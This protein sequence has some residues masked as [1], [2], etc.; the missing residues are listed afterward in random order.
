MFDSFFINAKK[1][2]GFGGKLMTKR[3]N[4]G[5]HA[6]LAE[7]GLSFSDIPDGAR[8]LDCG[9]GGGANLKRLL[10]KVDG[11]KV[12]GIDYSEVSIKQS[13]KTNRAAVRRG[14]CKPQ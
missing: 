11:G 13:F 14:V 10:Q 3:M 4:R 12:C 9:C 6:V 2:E 7:W 5:H 8:M 1:P